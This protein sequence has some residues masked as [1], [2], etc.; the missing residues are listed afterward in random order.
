M[1]A[2][3]IELRDRA[4]TTISGRVIDSVDGTEV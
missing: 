3:A 1:N 2:V 4:E